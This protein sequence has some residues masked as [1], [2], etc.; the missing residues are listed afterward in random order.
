M[1]W[2]CVS[3]RTPHRLGGWVQDFAALDA[4]EAKHGVAQP[5]GEVS[6]LLGLGSLLLIASNADSGSGQLCQVQN[7]SRPT[8][9]GEEAL[10]GNFSAH[11][12]VCPC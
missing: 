9:S 7:I 11:E 5:C 4:I 10:P 6:M 8:R 1:A 2:C 3:C 12:R